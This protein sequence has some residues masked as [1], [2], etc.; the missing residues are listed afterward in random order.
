MFGTKLLNLDF[1]KHDMT[2][3]NWVKCTTG[4]L[5]SEER[6]CDSDKRQC[7][8]SNDPI[9]FDHIMSE[10]D[11]NTI[12]D[13]VKLIVLSCDYKIYDSKYVKNLN[14]FGMKLYICIT[15]CLYTLIP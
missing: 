14:I 3:I 15:I 8:Q 4:R 10:K 7:L 13:A 1:E 6:K 9:N 2:E 12:N 11:R 5:S